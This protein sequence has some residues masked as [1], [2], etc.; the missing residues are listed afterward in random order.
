[1]KTLRV[2][3]AQCRQSAD[4]DENARTILRFLEEAGREKA[5]IVCFP[6]TP[7]V[8]YRVDISTPETP[9]EPE[10][11]D[12]LHSRVA[13]RSGELGLACIL[14]TETPLPSD[15]RR[16]RPFNTAL[17]IDSDGTILGRHHKTKL[18]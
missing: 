2:A 7:T 3:L 8:G 10:R 11:L 15:P 14:G 16:G 4:F 9:V 1:M 13:R 17:V 18:T 5:Q 6:E 12:D